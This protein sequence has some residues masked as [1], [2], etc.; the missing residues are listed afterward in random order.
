[1]TDL[2]L[3]L[4]AFL[5]IFMASAFYWKAQAKRKIMFDTNIG[6]V[7]VDLARKYPVMETVDNEFYGMDI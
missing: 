2:E 3:F 5:T 4:L 7:V 6:V 1:M